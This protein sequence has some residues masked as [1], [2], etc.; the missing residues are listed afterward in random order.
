M[1]ITYV[2]NQRFHSIRISVLRDATKIWKNYLYHR[3]QEHLFCII[4]MPKGYQKIGKKKISINNQVT[5]PFFSP[6]EFIDFSES[7]WIFPIFFKFMTIPFSK[8]NWGYDHASNIVQS[9]GKFS[10]VIWN[11]VTKIYSKLVTLRS[12]VKIF[13]KNFKN[14]KKNNWKNSYVFSKIDKLIWNKKKDRSADYLWDNFFCNMLIIYTF[15][16]IIIMQHKCFWH[17]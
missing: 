4:I 12:F 17:L 14:K 16:G 1:H 7:I 2:P 6:N 15:F 5:Y 8:K 13:E 3:C 9:P 11:L 10:C